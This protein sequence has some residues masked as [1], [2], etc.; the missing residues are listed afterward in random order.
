MKASTQQYLEGKRSAWL[1]KVAAIEAG[2]QKAISSRM[3]QIHADQF[4][5]DP[6]SYRVCVNCTHDAPPTTSAAGWDLYEDDGE[7]FTGYWICLDCGH[8]QR[9]VGT[10]GD[11]P[12]ELTDD[13]IGAISA[14]IGK[15]REHVEPR[16]QPAYDAKCE[17]MK[18]ERQAQADRMAEYNRLADLGYTDAQ[19]KNLM[20]AK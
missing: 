10:H 1:A 14:L 3:H 4:I 16:H 9:M 7:N 17:A 11:M 13:Q 20:E 18:A 5:G 8:I 6:N 12:A 2:D 19:I 15:H